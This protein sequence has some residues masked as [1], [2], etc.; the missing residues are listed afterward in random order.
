MLLVIVHEA[1]LFPHKKRIRKTTVAC[2]YVLRMQVVV[3]GK[4]LFSWISS[5]DT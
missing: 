1:N 2:V 4:V 3:E 5:G